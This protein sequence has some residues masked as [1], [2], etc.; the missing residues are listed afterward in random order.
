[1]DSVKVFSPARVDLAG[2]TLDIPPLHLFFNK[3]VTINCTLS[4]GVHLS[5]KKISG[6]SVVKNINTFEEDF[7]PTKKKSL[8]LISLFLEKTGLKQGVEIS[9]YSDFPEGSSLGVSSSILVSLFKIMEV[10]F[11]YKFNINKTVEVCR[12]L[13][14]IAIQFPAGYQDYLAPF[15]GGLNSFSFDQWGFKRERLRGI[16]LLKNKTI[17]AFTGRSHFSGKP[18]WQLFKGFFEGD[19]S[20]KEGFELIY[21]NSKQMLNAI[22]YGDIEKIASLLKRDFYIRKHML[23]SLVPD[24]GLFSILSQMEGVRGFR[25]CGAAQGGTVLIMVDEKER[26]KTIKEIEESGYDVFDCVLKNER[27]KV[28]YV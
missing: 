14:T 23:P 28:E 25:M 20:I 7:V 11:N 9:V 26:D 1:M 21:E 3:P 27:V 18:N 16:S 6:K 22:K 17:F 12:R 19:P 8:T 5:A 15:Y 10:L 13:E 4:K 24:I 2:G